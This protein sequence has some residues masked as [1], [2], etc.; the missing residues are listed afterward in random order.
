M[1]L[2]DL[3]FRYTIDSA[4]DF[5]FGQSVGSLKE[6]QS[7]FTFA[8]A[9]NY[10]QEA[11]ITRI[12]LGPL[13]IFYRDQKADKCN[14]ICREFARQFVE[15]AIRAVESEKEDKK[16]G[17]L[18]T[19]RQKY[20]FSHELARRLSDKHRIL[21]ELMNVLLAGRDTTASLLSNLFF[22]LAK[23][24]AIWDRLRKEVSGLQGRVPTYEELQNLKYVQCCITECEKS[25]LLSCLLGFFILTHFISATFTSSCTTK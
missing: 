13:N 20:I 22:M 24:P 16:K 2:Q 23:K 12:T 7:K 1:D 3:F 6:T 9:F 11:I 4:T 19:K 21:D 17:Q 8:Q 14:H 25:S 18:E 15:A 10:A 5:L